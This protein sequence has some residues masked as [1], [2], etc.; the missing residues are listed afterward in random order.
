MNEIWV[1]SV[2][3]MMLTAECGRNWKKYMPHY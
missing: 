3:E 1:C 2:G